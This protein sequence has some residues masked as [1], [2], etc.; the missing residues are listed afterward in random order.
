M[1]STNP[2]PVRLLIMGEPKGGKT[3]SLIS[4]L[5]AGYHVRV[6]DLDNNTNVLFNFLRKEPE[7]LARL[8]VQTCTDGFV[9][10]EVLEGSPPRKVL[11]SIP[12]ASAWPSAL[13]LLRDWPSFGPIE[14]WG[15]DVVFVLDT[16]SSLSQ[17]AMAFHL[18]LNGRTMGAALDI[19]I[20]ATQGYIRQILGNLR[21]T[22]IKCN[23]IVNTHVD[24][25]GG[26]L[27]TDA[28]GKRVFVPDHIDKE[29]ERGYPMTIGKALNPVIAAY[30]PVF[31]LA[32]AVGS[33][34]SERRVLCT[35]TT[36][37]GSAVITLA[38]A[39]PDVPP[40]LPIETGLA[41]YFRIVRGTEPGRTP[42]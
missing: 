4:L 24:Y 9:Q 22:A 7:A 10:K 13:A 27:W 36:T 17:A 1:K 19:D 3:G 23:V 8:D 33:G 30:F 15:E 21:S 38:S 28:S 40:E 11:R 41:E 34:Q 6:L 32:K 39:D 42:K 20:G 5:R 14:T 37:S 35:R 18:E 16:L 2:K 26:N 12:V 29:I 31:F 25:R